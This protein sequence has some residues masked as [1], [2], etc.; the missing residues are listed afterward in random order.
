[1]LRADMLELVPEGKLLRCSKAAVFQHFWSW[2]GVAQQACRGRLSRDD[3][4]RNQSW[5]RQDSATIS[6]LHG[7]ACCGRERAPFESVVAYRR[8]WLSQVRGG[9]ARSH[10]G[11]ERLAL[12]ILRTPDV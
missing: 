3:G 9:Q 1:M 10:G 11:C 6:V 2:T 5:V 7:R 12:S 4:G 8:W